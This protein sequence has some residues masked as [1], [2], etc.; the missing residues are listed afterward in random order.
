MEP[1]HSY[2]SS[3]VA[4]VVAASPDEVSLELSDATLVVRVVSA[5]S[6]VDKPV[7]VSAVAVSV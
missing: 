1:T 4:E 3:A 7:V 5:E 2:D 6:S